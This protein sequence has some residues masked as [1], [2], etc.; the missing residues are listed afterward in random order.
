MKRILP[1]TLIALVA[2]AA[3]AFAQGR[4]GPHAGGPM[5]IPGAGPDAN[6]L[7]DYLGLTAEQQANWR[8][9]Q[10]E[11]R[12]STEALHEQQRTLAEQLRTALD[13]TDATAVG[14][15]ML[16]IRSIQTQIEVAHDAAEA[17]FKS[18]LT[19]EQ[20]TKFDAFRAAAD[21]LRQ[22]GPGGP[23]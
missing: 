13:G 12:T 4:P 22:R 19:A 21:Y 20:Q 8:S 7:A 14:N 2:F 18:T 5:A 6:I 11:L 16:Q 3:V 23:H 17:K 9:I 10:S 1:I 15:L